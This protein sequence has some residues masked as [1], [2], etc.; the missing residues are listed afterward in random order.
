LYA[1]ALYS[2]RSPEPFFAGFSEFVKRQGLLP[3][4]AEFVIVGGSSDLDLAAMAARYNVSDY[5]RLVG[6]VSHDEALRWM[7]SATVLLAVQSPED[8]VH[9]P[10]KLFEYIGAGRPVFAMSKP[11]EVADMIQ[12][13]SLGWVA[14]PDAS[15]VTA[16]LTEV[17]ALWRKGGHAGLATQAAGRF[18]VGESTRQLAAVLEEIVRDNPRG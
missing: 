11:C 17:H 16:K 15:A 14:E 6:R 12:K 2:S 4:N 1:G 8:N 18:S 3:S 7:Q 9:V 10:G 13:F 5:L